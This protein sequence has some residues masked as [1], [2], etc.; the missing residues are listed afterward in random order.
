[1]VA[2]GLESSR[3]AGPSSPSVSSG[4]LRMTT[5]W[6]FISLAPTGV[7]DPREMNGFQISASQ[8]RFAT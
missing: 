6:E 7:A 2:T 4:S 8:R 1:M 3:E 5:L